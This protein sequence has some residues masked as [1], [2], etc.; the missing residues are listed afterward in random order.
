[1][2]ISGDSQDSIEW[3]ATGFSFGGFH[4]IEE[5]GPNISTAFGQYPTF[6]L[7]KSRS[8]VEGY[9]AVL[10]GRRRYDDIL[11]LG[12]MK[13][14]SCV[15]FNELLKPQ[16]HLA[17]DIYQHESD[18]MQFSDYVSQQNRRFLAR[19]DMS[20]DN[21]QGIVAAYEEAFDVDANFDLIVDDASHNYSLS[22]ESF[23]GLFPRLRA[24]GIYALE[25][26]GWAHWQGQFQDKNHS[27]ANNAA[28]SNLAIHAV[29]ACT[30]AGGIISEVIVTPNTTFIVRGS[31]QVPLG[32]RVES[33]VPLRGREVPLY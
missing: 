16:R 5:F 2:A 32:W 25:D 26:W 11:E 30:G 4:F 23:N 7:M 33:A 13:G 18:L 6:V 29:L 24:R 20:Q 22:L 8:I 3:V 12:I 27:E 31:V 28:L 10:R 9:V 21:V 14:G 17:I 19:F 15:F 1:M